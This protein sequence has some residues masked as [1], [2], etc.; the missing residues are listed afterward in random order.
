MVKAAE[1]VEQTRC[2]PQLQMAGMS[3]DR[4]G[5]DEAEANRDKR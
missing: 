2:K 3:H 1:G 5:P 4:P